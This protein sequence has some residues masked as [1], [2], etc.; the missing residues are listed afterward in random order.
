MNGFTKKSIRTLT[1]GEKLKKLRSDKRISLNEVSRLT[2][3]QIA[4]LEYLEEGEYEKLPAD[5]YVKGFLRSYA[6]FLGVDGQIML[7][8][9]EKEKGIRNNLEKKRKPKK[10]KVKPLNVSSFI[11]TPQKILFLAIFVIVLCGL[12]FLFREI[13]SFGSQ[14]SLVIFSPENNSEVSENSI[15]VEGTT[16]KDALLFINE[17]PIL[18]GDEG[19]FKESVTLQAGINSINIKAINKFE[20]ETQNNL[21]I[22]LNSQEE[23][24][25]E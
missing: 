19:K 15:F 3:I 6:D 5:V 24:K 8:L 7:K 23:K 18:V 9:Y 11:F 13:N 1:L 25:D 2:K 14:P 20:K 21:V 16:D 10:E 4:Y 12:I 22:K 17:Q